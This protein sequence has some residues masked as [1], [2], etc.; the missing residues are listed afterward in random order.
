MLKTRKKWLSI[1][2]TLAMLVGLMVPLA[3]PALA[4]STYSVS[5]VI[6]VSAGQVNTFT[7]P[8][9]LQISMDSTTASNSAGSSIV[10]DLPTSPSNFGM[11]VGNVVYSG[12]FGN[13]TSI[14]LNPS[15]PVT[16]GGSTYYNEY[17]LKINSVDASNTTATTGTISIPINA[18][19]VPGGANGS[20]NITA[21]APNGSVFSNGT[22]TV[23]TAGSGNVNVAIESVNSISAAS[24]QSLGVIDV[25]ESM[26]GALSGSGALKFTLPPGFSWNLPT[27]AANATTV[28]GS[29]LNFGFS[30]ANNN[31]ELDLNVT[32]TSTQAS[33]IK[34][35]DLS[36]NVDQ[37]VA[38]TGTVTVS[39]SGAN[40]LSSMDVANYGDYGL[41]A[42]ALG[43]NNLVAGKAAQDLGEFQIKE[44]L[45][46]SLINNRTITLSLPAGLKWAKFPE[47]DNN[48]TTSSGVTVNWQSVGSDAQMIQGTVQGIPNGTSSAATLVFKK[49]EVT[50]AI[51]FSGDV[52]VTLG[53]S[54]GLTGTLTLGK[55]ASGITVST[56]STP[57]DVKIG[58][59]GQSV[60][61]LT[62]TENAAGNID[63]TITY[64]AIDTHSTSGNGS[65][66]GLVIKNSTNSQASLLVTLPA[67]VTYTSTPT[68]SVTSGDLQL[69]TAAATT[70]TDSTGAGVFTIPVKSTS[71]TPSTIKISGIK[72]TI[73]RTVPEGPIAM[74]VKGTA[75]NESTFY[76]DGTTIKSTDSA[77]FTNNTTAAKVT[78]AN[79]VT[80]APEPTKAT[81]VFTIGNTTFTVNGVASTMDVAP[82]VANDRTYV[83]VRYA[84]QA[85]GVSPDNILY[86]DGKV[87]LIKGDRV[88]QLTIGSNVML[89]NGVAITMD[90]NATTTNDRTMLPL[91]WVGQALGA[92]V[93]W[94]N[95]TQ[96]VTMTM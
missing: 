65:T 32:S 11:S 96:T 67:G 74:K 44:N 62:I 68:I 48:L 63:S 78:V 55:V 66:Y 12:T 53:G 41:T 43:S 86:N 49:A 61:D 94:D 60:G 2:L 29:G 15:N 90:V 80:P 37:S 51:D 39:V 13:G 19:Y 21:S 28:W 91:R 26:A 59:A 95:T 27:P 92:T 88:V 42:T 85:L 3:A 52:A 70:S 38:K 47:F 20:V 93:N 33:W 17:T 57:P 69:D 54:E 72:I 77:I 8:I 50:P 87:T 81:V 46:G 4:A 79:C 10:L 73:D 36:I 75:V 31:R 83:P 24:N 6:P 35:H 58:M 25:K 1:L 22:I 71:T 45:A 82:Y 9:F 89:I 76:A 64:S 23:A 56:S 40:N 18:M 5:T 34:L 84:A 16:V 7:P 30:L 14:S